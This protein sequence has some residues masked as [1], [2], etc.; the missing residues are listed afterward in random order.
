MAEFAPDQ[1]V[2][3]AGYNRAGCEFAGIDPTVSGVDV[4]L[5]GRLGTCCGGRLDEDL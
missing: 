2:V 4:T 5:M 3:T 1:R